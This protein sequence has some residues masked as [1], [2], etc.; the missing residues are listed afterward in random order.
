MA[1]YALY[2]FELSDSVGKKPG[3]PAKIS[4]APYVYVG[5]TGKK[6]RERLKEHRTG[7]Y[8][9]DKRWMKHYA[10]TRADLWADWPKYATKAD[11][12]SA[13]A[14]L[15]AALGEQGYTVVNK[16]GIALAIAKKAAG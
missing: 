6:R 4:A 1:R 10:R 14:E 9:A 15:A 3:I 12:L 13:E 16:T 2:V 5:Y 8:A 11:A 7:Y